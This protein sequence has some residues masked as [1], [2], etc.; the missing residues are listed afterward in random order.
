M[1]A[2]LH[3][4]VNGFSAIL[5]KIT[6]EVHVFRDDIRAGRLR[7][8]RVSPRQ[9]RLVQAARSERQVGARLP[10]GCAN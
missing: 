7:R 9:Q 6:A 5:P 10:A 8:A 3:G 4:K 1:V 2:E